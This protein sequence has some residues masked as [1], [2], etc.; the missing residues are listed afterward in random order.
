MIP[1]ER[2]ERVHLMLSIMASAGGWAHASDEP[3]EWI[4]HFC[5]DGEPDTLNLAADA[6]LIDVSHDSLFDTS[7]AR[8]SAAGRQ[9]LSTH[10]VDVRAAAPTLLELRALCDYR[11][12]RILDLLARALPGEARQFHGLSDLD[13]IALE[14]TRAVEAVEGADATQ[15]SARAQL[16]ILAAMTRAQDLALRDNT[17]MATSDTEAARDVLAERRR[18]VEAEGWTLEHDDAHDAGE[19]SAAGA[20]YA[21]SA[22]LGTTTRYLALDPT[23][24]WP[25]DPSWWKPKSPRE[26]LVRAGALILAEIER[27]DRAASANT[28]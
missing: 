16:V 6:G 19:M 25:W 28:P 1:R 23:G 15:R 10:D 14:A 11:R 7:M 4:A 21:M 26:D 13:E 27:M 3:G 5:G 17:R 22:Y 8:L 24:F 18:Q 20:A 9:F 2:R 12:A